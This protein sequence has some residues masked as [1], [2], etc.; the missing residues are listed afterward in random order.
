MRSDY[1]HW[2]NSQELGA[3]LFITS[4]CLDFAHLFRR[5]EMREFLAK[6]L[7]QQ[8]LDLGARLHAFVVMTHHFHTISS[9]PEDRTCSWLVQKIKKSASEQM[10][11]LLTTAEKALVSQQL[12]L[13]ERQFWMRSFRGIP[14]KDERMMEN[15]SIYIHWNPIRSGFCEQ[16]TA[17]RWS[18]AW[19]FE[20]DLYDLDQ[21]LKLSD[22]LSAFSDP[23]HWRSADVEGCV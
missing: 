22:C 4:T 12:G 10:V 16:P 23:P 6:H 18:S 5:D 9:A 20:R 14:I 11:E 7:L 15:T 13:N 1:K 3:T 8:R 17:Y 2:R 19:L 21:G